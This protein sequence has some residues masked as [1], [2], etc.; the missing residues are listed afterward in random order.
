MKGECCVCNGAHKLD[1]ENW[2]ES[3]LEEDRLYFEKEC[4]YEAVACFV[5]EAK[6]RVINNPCA[7]EALL[8]CAKLVGD[9]DAD[10][11]DLV[12]PHC[13]NQLVAFHSWC[14]SKGVAG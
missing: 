4:R 8:S 2:C 7:V 12:R 5:D 14:K 13:H 6:E 3:C 11:F 9:L 10:Y 1:A